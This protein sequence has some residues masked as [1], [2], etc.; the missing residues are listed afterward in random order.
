MEV[1]DTLAHLIGTWT[2]ARTIR[3]H[4]AGADGSF[5]G[6]LSVTPEPGGRAAPHWRARYEERGRFRLGAHD[7]P[8]A[9][10]LVCVGR[11]DGSVLLHLPNGRPFVV[12]DLRSGTWRACHP[13]AED[14]YDLR[15][16][17]VAAEVLEEHWRVRGP[18]KDYEAWTTYRRV[19]ARIGAS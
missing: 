13:C 7:G 5:E 10:S 8:A 11:E 9:R 19:G 2:V 17:V 15:F 4:R 14:R 18:A 3:D 6:T 16:T 12:C 1:T